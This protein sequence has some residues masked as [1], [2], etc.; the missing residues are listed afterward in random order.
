MLLHACQTPPVRKEA[1]NIKDDTQY[2]YQIKQSDR[3]EMNPDHHNVM[4]AMMALKAYETGDTAKLSKCVADSLAVYY[5]GG[6]YKGGK[7]EFMYA[8]KETVKALKSLR[9]EIKD[10]ESVISKDKQQEK[11]ITW[12]TQ[13]WINGQ[14]QSDS[15][16]VVDQ[17][18][19]KNGKIVV[20]YDYTR[21]YKTLPR[22][23][24]EVRE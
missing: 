16:D 7:R 21:R 4:I 24:Q 18:F 12:Y 5:D 13:H 11:V 17:A 20:W 6:Y 3:W 22:P 19:F 10:W 15:V 1:I 8:I 9:L 23:S 2:A 14:G